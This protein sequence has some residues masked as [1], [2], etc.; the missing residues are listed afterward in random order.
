M[1]V[2]IA[3]LVESSLVVPSLVV[4]SLVEPAL[5]EPALP[6]ELTSLPA[7]HDLQNNSATRILKVEASNLN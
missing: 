6:S 2:G 7:S 5:V 3:A 1:V 4:P